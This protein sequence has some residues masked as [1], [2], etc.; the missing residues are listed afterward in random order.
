MGWKTF[1]KE[2]HSLN[3]TYGQ[4]EGPG[5]PQAPGGASTSVNGGEAADEPT[6]TIIT[7]T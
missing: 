5:G 2:G 4:Q 6:Q 7:A 3:L 1:Q